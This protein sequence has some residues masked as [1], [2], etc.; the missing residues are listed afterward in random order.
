[1]RPSLNKACLRQ[2]W[3]SCPNLIHLPRWFSK[4]ARCWITERHL[5]QRR[6]KEDNLLQASLPPDEAERLKALRR[7]EILDTDPEQ[8]YDDMT[9]LASHLCGT[10]IAMVSLVD[11]NRQWFKS[12]VGVAASETSRD[13]AFCAHGILQA[14][15][16]VVN[17]AQHDQRFA[18]N[19]LVT[20][21]TKLRFYAGAPLI[22]SDGHALGMLC[23]NDQVPRD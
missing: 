16:F 12:K 23:V 19:P 20:G 2:E 8:D 1:M 11:E 5:T 4:C 9:L 14:E 21:D 3:S 15:V 6:R 13:I 7:Y 18:S 17:D 22:T 10:P